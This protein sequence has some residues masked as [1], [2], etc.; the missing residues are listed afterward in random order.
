MQDYEYI[1]EFVANMG[2]ELLLSGAT[3]ERANDSMTRILYAYHYDEISIF[4]LN[5]VIILSVRLKDGTY[6]SRQRAVRGTGIHMARLNAL[7]N[8]SRKVCKETP[9]PKGLHE[10]LAD[11]I[12]KVPSYSLPVI[13][14]MTI[15]AQICLNLILG[16]N[17]LDA[18][19]MAILAAVI[20][21]INTFMYK[22][23]MNRIIC[24][25]ITMFIAASIGQG[26]V[27]IGLCQNIYLLL[28]NCCMYLLPGIPLVF[29]VKNILCGNE[30]NGAVTLL[31]VFLEMMGIVGGIALAEMVFG[32]G[33]LIW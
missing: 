13:L 6:C 33:M 3:L 30:I 26:M 22:P 15:C 28:T 31:R 23:G 5:S 27:H 16:G 21:C 11:T 9:D 25:A 8:L 24:S 17:A 7:N 18:C 14:L 10:M 20:F 1:C 19:C 29:A 2:E 32:G 4:S 12:E